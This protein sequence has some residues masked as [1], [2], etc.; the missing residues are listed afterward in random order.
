MPRREQVRNA[1]TA[2]DVHLNN[3]RL[4]FR[5]MNS[6]VRLR[7]SI[8]NMR[9]NV[10]G[11]EP[12]DYELKRPETAALQR[13]SL[14]AILR[15]HEL[16][17]RDKEK[18]SVTR[19]WCKEIPLALQV[20][21]AKSFH[22]AF[23]D[24]WALP[25]S[26]C[27]FCY[28]KQAPSELTTIRWRTRLAPSLL[29]ATTA[30][31]K[32]TECFPAGDDAEA[33][34]CHECSAALKKGR[35][36]KACAVNNMHIGCEHR[37]PEELDGLSPLEERLIALQVPFGYITKFTVDN[38]TPSGLSYRK[39]VKGHIVVFPNKVEDLVATVLPHPLLET[40]ENIHVS[41]SGSSK[42]GA[43]DVG[44]L[45][46]VRKSRVRA[47]LTWLQKNN[48]LYEHITIDHGE[49]DGWQ[50]ADGSHVPIPVMA[51]MQREEP[52]VAEKAQ[53]DH[54]VPD[55]DRGLEENRFTSIEEIVASAQAQADHN[56]NLPDD[57]T[58]PSE[59]GPPLSDDPRTSIPGPEDAGGE[60]EVILETTSSGMF[61]LDGPAAFEEAD[62]LSFLVGA[63]GT[64]RTRGADEAERC[65]MR[66]QGAGGQPFI[67]V[68]RGADFADSLHEDFFPRTFPKLFPW[69]RGGP[70]APHVPH[71]EQQ[72]APAAVECRSN[73]SLSYW[74]RY[75]L[76]RHG[77]RFA[78]HPVFC[79]LVFNILLR[80]SNRRISMVRTTKGSFERVEQVYGTMTEDRLKKAEDEMRETRK[81]QDADVAFLLRELSIFGHAQPL[82]NETRLLMRRKIQA[83]DIWAGTPVIWI[84]INPNDI[85]NPV[86]MKLAIHRLHDYETAKDLLAD[87]RARYDGIALSTMDPVS[88]A[89]FFH[90]EISLFFEKYVRA[91]N[92]SVFGKVSHYYATVETNDRGSLH[93][94]GLLWLH[95]NMELPSLVDDIA[96]P[97]EEEYRDRVVR[98]VDSVFHECLDEDAG[99]A[100]RQ[101]RKPIHPVEG[102]MNDTEALS[103]AF[104]AEANFIAH[105]CQV[106]SHTYTCIK[107]SLKGLTDHDA[108]NYRRTACRFKAPWKIV[109]ATGLSDDGLL[110]IRRNHPLVNRYNK[111]MAVG[112][113]HNHDVSMILTR[114]KGLAM[115]FYITNYATK[116]DT[117]MWRRIAHAAEVFRQ[118]R[119]DAESRRDASAPANPAAQR[120]AVLNQSRQFLMRVANRIFSERQLSAV[121]V[122][123]HMLGYETDFTNVPHWSFLNLNA[124][125]WAIFRRWKHLRSEAGA[126]TEGEEPPET[127]QLREG[128]RTLLCLDAY[129]YRGRVLRDICLYDYMSMVTL[130][131]NRGRDEDGN[132]ISL[133]VPS[134][135]SCNWFQKLRR[136]HEYA[137]PIFQGFISDDHRDEHP[138]YFRRNSVLHLALFVPWERFLP[139]MQGDIADLWLG[140]EASLCRRLRFHV[141][142]ISLLTKSA[143]DARKDAKLWASRSEGDDTVDVDF[144]LDEEDD[145]EQCATVAEHHQNF[146]ALLR[147]LHNAVRDTDVTRGSPVLTNFI[148]DLREEYSA[149]GDNPF[150]QR[151]EGFYRQIRRAQGAPLCQCETLSV[152][153]VQAAAKAQEM[154]HLRMLDEMETGPQGGTRHSP[155]ADIDDMLAQHYDTDIPL[156]HRGSQDIVTQ[157]PRMLV[158]IDMASCFT[159]LGR[160]AASQHTLNSLQTMAL[161]LVCRFLDK[162]SAD[163][164]RAGQHLQYTGGPGGTGKSRVIEAL[165][166]VFSARGQ[167]HLLQITGTSG[168]AA[169]QIGGTTLH[170]ACG[171]DTHRAPD[172]RI[173]LFSEAKKFVWKQKLV[174][175]ID[176]VSMLGG[177][178]LYE[179]SCRLQ[180]L[181][182][183]PDK[184]FGGIP[185]VLLMGDF[186]QFAP[187]RETSLLVD[188][189][190]NPASARLSQATVAHHRGFSLWL[191]FKTVVLLDEQIRARD[192]PELG[193]LLDRVR[194]GT[195]TWQDLDLLNTK[196]VDRSDIT[197]SNGLRA[198]TPLNRNRWS[199]N[200]QAVVDWARFN[201]RHIS[202]FVS[203]H[204]WRRAGLSQ[205]EIAQ[206]I[207]Q[208]D[209]SKCKVPGIFFYAQGMP[210]VVNKNIYT[211]LKVVNG[212]EFAAADIITDPKYPGYHL[213]DD[214]TIH[215]GPPLAILLHSNDTATLAVPVLP[216]KMVLVRP[217]SHV[218]EPS[219]SRFKF[220]STKA[221]SVNNM[222][223]GCEHRYPEELDGLSPV[224]ERL[225]ALQVPFGYIT[226]FTV[227]NKT[228]SDLSYRTHVRGHIVVFPNKVEDLVATVLPHP[229]LQSVEDIHISWSGSSKPGSADVRHLLQVRKSRVR[230]ALSWLQKNNP[231]YE[232][233]E[234][235][236]A[237]IDGWHYADGSDV[238]TLI[239]DRM[240]REEPSTFEKTQTDHIVPDTDRGLAENRLTSIDELLGSMNAPPADE[241]SH[242]DSAVNAPP[243]EQRQPSPLVAETHV[244]GPTTTDGDVNTVCET[245]TS[246]MFPLDGPAAFAEA[247]KLSFLSNVV[248]SSQ[249][250]APDPE[251]C[252]IQIQTAGDQPYIR[253]ER[254][255]DFA[256]NLHEDFFPRTFP[257]LFPW[258][259]GGPKA[260]RESNLSPRLKP[261]GRQSSHSL[262]YWTRYVLQRHGGRFATH[263]VFC[264]LV[265][266]I[267][268]RSSNRRISMVRVA[269]DSFPKLEQVHLTLTADQLKRAEAEIRETGT[270]S[271]RDV[272]FLLRELSIF[273]HAQPL[274]NETRLLM[275]RKIQALSI[276]TGMPAIWITINP[277]DVNNPIKMMLSVHRLHDCDAAKSLLADLRG[278]Y[279]EIALSIMDPVSSAIF[280]HREI[281]LFFDKYVKA[282]KESVFGKISHYYATVETNERGSLHLHGLLWL[283]GNVQLPS[284]ID[285]M[286]NPD[287]GAYRAQVVRYVDS[288]FHECLDEDAGK[289]VRK[290]RKPIQ[291]I[292]EMMA[293]SQTLTAAFDDESNFIAH[294][295]Q[296]HSHTFTCLK[297]SLKGLVEEGT[298]KHRRTACRFKAPWK[299][300]E[301]TG[302]TDDGLLRIRRNH[303][304]VNRYNKSLAIGLRYNHD[305][306]MIL[307][308]TK[309]LAMVYYITNYATKLD[310]P[311]WKRLALAADVARQLRESGSARC[312]ATESSQR[313]HRHEAVM[314]ES[315]QFL[316]RTANRIFSERQ[317]SAVEVCYHLLGYC[318]DF[319][320]VPHWSFLNL[321]ALYWAIFRQW[322][323]L[324]H[325]A[326]EL[327]DGQEPSETVPVRE[328]G[329]TLL[330]LD[331]YAYRGRVLRDLCLYDYM[332]MIHLVRR[333]DRAEDESHIALDESAAE[334]EGWIQRLRRP[335]EYA[336]PIFQGFIS[337]DHEDE[338]PVYIKR[339]SVLHLA[340]FVPWEDFLSRTQG[341]ITDIWSSCEARLS[342]R[343]RFHVSNIGLLRKSAEDARRDAR[344]W[345]SRSEGD[346]TVDVEYA[347]GGD[348]YGEEPATTAHQHQ[349]YTALLQVLQSAVRDSDVTRGS[350][351][352]GGLIDD[353][354]AVNSVEERNPLVQYQ[355]DCYGKTPLNRDGIQAAAKAQ[356]LLHLRMLDEIETGSQ[357]AALSTDGAD[358][359]GVPASHCDSD[360]ATMH[361]RANLIIEQHGPR[362]LVDVNPT[363]TFVE[364]GHVVATSFTL[365]YL[366]SMALHLVCRF[367]DKITVDPDNR[368]FREFRCPYRRHD[369][370]FSLWV[371]CPSCPKQTT[372]TVLGSEEVGME[373]E[374]VLVIDEVSMLGGAT[375]HDVSRHLQALRDCP[376]EPFGGIPVVLLMGDFHQF[377][378]VLETSLLISR[379]PD[380][381]EAP[382]RQATISHHSG[383]RLWHMFKTVV[384]L[385][386]QVRARN[387][388]QFG[389][390]L[391][392]VR[393]GLQSQQDLD[394][395]NANIVGRP[396]SH[397]TMVC[398]L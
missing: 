163:P 232:H 322:P 104:D 335:E 113:R 379:F 196:L 370:P 97:R 327:M 147:T 294:C 35:L 213:A 268:L 59:L 144:P 23:T 22:Q 208:G 234:I 174:L 216:P 179:A 175:V 171:L 307:T 253:V 325:Q 312:R 308:R 30:L 74:A 66:L 138:V 6:G 81:T 169:A 17:F 62:K 285:D 13:E 177:T 120:P 201:G 237:E 269:K 348:D 124:L 60:S 12:Q 217:I 287:E 383:C 51:S 264:F 166:W 8:G 361:P 219:D 167:A 80:S 231:L 121:E 345:A 143:E 263:P 240:Q 373:P 338:H 244:P 355:Q 378:P 337:D 347:L 223:I 102:M 25:I 40:I 222:A 371:G 130:V 68:E 298:D 89:I 36:P 33:R 397:F 19:S 46:Q 393:N 93:L 363:T 115:V 134:P 119:E 375:L 351:V 105:C 107:Y 360:S 356:N 34:V 188:R 162:S 15:Y 366:Q 284:L 301:E 4:R 390:L 367:L 365:N 319:T 49:I 315:R 252:A 323:H 326:S 37:Y 3:I 20:E 259:K 199:L 99:K 239:M 56:S 77:G 204:T 381:P 67:L 173:P 215:F 228:R 157:G 108:D 279:D 318:T 172:K 214:V 55:T 183:C 109:D 112:L 388:P 364:M 290:E 146:A 85:N 92:Q 111:A 359:G 328:G 353:L 39:H 249:D 148:R 28:R 198:I 332:S 197:F 41:W 75:V 311:M 133:E 251:P 372:A 316:M 293:S 304:L 155:N 354:C 324:R 321:T 54:I 291:P 2:D 339:N 83:I 248:N 145:G 117:P 103:A 309:G 72:Q 299:L 331:A 272:S 357:A 42:P 26:H 48:P 27:S 181:R 313:N 65:A 282:G 380:R 32:C 207:E 122:C 394:L 382:M 210:V 180:S 250:L 73:H 281:S 352:L 47:A 128:G 241:C 384:L 255:A 142:N 242:V 98:Y 7:P 118:L 289:A 52:S 11:C 129:A 225:I 202:V 86:K 288:V 230:A 270:T 392:R 395:L 227:D 178:T 286:A 176:E 317:L 314:N 38:K 205:Y 320:N 260:L 334:Y 150:L 184:P 280:F 369:N 44:H 57:G 78:T 276:W 310:T 224:E 63:I 209:D 336:V 343:L 275:R 165:K 152:E 18:E 218:L 341:A 84:T 229:L 64:N 389:A 10:R 330:N 137:V 1:G 159:E 206:A 9:R 79:F 226:K 189:V 292:A 161:Q 391:D 350:P 70:K 160:L 256:D 96:D 368:H 362:I 87:L 29:R 306:S 139:T 385:E 123:Y 273:G 398:V 31:Q 94:H 158:D 154:L 132:H 245:S 344:L 190:A 257:K 127:V 164:D 182:D 24:E 110:A 254:G 396:K 258:G 377:A 5:R 274:S 43:A 168:S 302:F 283:D 277:N 45:L 386:E 340:L 262:A 261:V 247:D 21:T 333:K 91:G 246:G 90:R 265:F 100:I 14:E 194:H 170:S 387:D 16:R 238:P 126:E 106:H 191:M 212:A 53:T 295:C 186:Y 300:V 296:V 88:S 61:P 243:T 342:P 76:Q 141:S 131:R 235:N 116:L 236:Q 192:D 125:Y 200:M 221:C 376:D 114:A 69:G 346:D 153:D 297:Y 135:E 185:V 151:P 220:L 50:Y 266:N 156:L 303:P 101:E 278:R 58:L 71:G 374:A 271:D 203:T 187:V 193:A 305:V 211:G 95:G 233:V 349:N 329:R 195:Q 149:L 136:P 267:L 140:H 82:S 358:V